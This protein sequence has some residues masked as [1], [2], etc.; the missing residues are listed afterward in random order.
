MKIS[1]LH[2]TR[3]RPAQANHAKETW[4]ALAQS[5]ADIEH[6]FAVD[7]D[8][9]TWEQLDQS[10][11]IVTTCRPNMGCVAAWNLAA[12]WSDGEIL[13]QMSDDYTPPMF[14]D[15]IILSRLNTDLS[16]VLAVS[17]GHRTDHLL[18]M[19][20]ITRQRY[21]EQ[22]YT[23]FHP[24]YRGVFSDDHLTAMAYGQGRVIEA[25]DVV[26]VHAHPLWTGANMDDTYERQNAP[27]RYRDGQRVFRS[28]VPAEYQHWPRKPLPEPTLDLRYDAVQVPTAQPTRNV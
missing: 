21:R 26:F 17:D 25:R 28:L 23:M 15:R 24:R 6:I 22:G 3:N 11:Q 16:Q 5:P 10:S 13:V 4:L 9:Q 8:D 2:A 1:L 27:E 7:P 20:I 12:L 14:W 18:C 19:A